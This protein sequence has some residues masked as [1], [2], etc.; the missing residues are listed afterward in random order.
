MQV[1]TSKQT[2]MMKI[3]SPL[4]YPGGKSRIFP[5]VSH[6]LEENDMKGIAYAEPYAGGAGLALKLLI[7]GWVDHI[8]INDLNSSIYTF[9][10]VLLTRTDE[11]CDWIASVDVTMKNWRLYKDIQKNQ[12]AADELEL[13][14][15]TLFLNRT[16]ISGVIKGGPIGGI[17]QTGAYKIDVRFN[18]EELIKKIRLIA[19]FKGKI[20]L[21]NDDGLVFLK[22]ISRKREDV[23]VYLD[24]P[25]YKKAADLY[26]NFFTD[27]NHEDLCELM[28][29]YR[30]R[31]M[32]SYDNE[33]FVLKLYE[34]FRKIEY[35]LAQYASNRVGKEVLIFDKRVK[36]S[37]SLD[38]LVNHREL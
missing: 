10:K 27:K 2:D 35:Q 36:C 31:W 5:F 34:K 12:E 7:E 14:K 23:F 18:K 17:N 37:S 29:S 1:L 9:W 21:S 4:R 30:K 20:H 8:Y 13:A 19:T 3:Y 25:Y 6:L 33:D 26:M 32:V 24:P 22:K 28:S 38:Y 16:N 15:S 11:L